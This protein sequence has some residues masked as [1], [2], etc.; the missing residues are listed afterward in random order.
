VISLGE[1]RERRRQK[2]ELQTRA[3]RFWQHPGQ[4]AALRVGGMMPTKLVLSIAEAA[5]VLGVSDDLIYELTARGEL[6]CLRL[7]R[8]KVIPTVAIQA[9]I[10]GSLEGFPIKPRP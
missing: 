6:P 9:V 1:L 10:D 8:R 2:F 7:G 3:A 4:H 5:E